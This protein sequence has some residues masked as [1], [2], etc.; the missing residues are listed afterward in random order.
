[1]DLERLY[2]PTEVSTDIRRRIYNPEWAA[3]DGSEKKQAKPKVR[4]VELGTKFVEAHPR[5]VILGGPGAGKTTFLKY[6]ALAYSDKKVFD[7]TGLTESYLPVYLHLPLLP[8]EGMDVLQAAAMQVKTKTDHRAVSFYQRLFE[9]GNIV[10]LLD[11]LDE[12]ASENREDVVRAISKFSATYPKARII[13]SCRTADYQQV[14]EGFDEV[15]VARLSPEAVKSIVKEWFFND[16]SRADKLISML[17][18]D[19]AV[20]ALTETPLLLSLLCIQYR[21]D[22]ALP[23]RKTELYRR[24]V[25]ALIRDWDASR[26]FRRDSQYSQLSDDRKEMIFECVAGENSKDGI[27]FEFSEPHL[28]VTLSDVIARFGLSGNDAKGILVEIESHH[29]ILEKC[30]A[31]TYQFSHGTMHE[32]FVAR[33]LVATR[34]EMTALKQ[35][36]DDDRWH[37]VIA[38]M[39]AII[40]DPSRMLEFLVA[41]SSTQNFKNYPTFGKR[42]AHLLLL[43]RCMTMGVAIT[44][45]LRSA[46]CDHLIKSQVHMIVQLHLDKVLPYASRRPNGIGQT[47]VRYG[48]SRPRVSIDKLLLPYRSLLN[49]VYLSPLP[50][51]AEKVIKECPLQWERRDLSVYARIGIITCLLAPIADVKP[52]EFLNY[53]ERSADELRKL[54]AE[55]VRQ[56]VVESMNTHKKGFPDLRAD[57]LHVA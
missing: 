46:I 49:E 43:Y 50:D 55:A 12:V 22:L 39:C 52:Q 41:N 10:L 36:Y 53:M 34:Q 20:A 44:P 31:E 5:T 37:T 8:R 6:L 45:P 23:K 33:H 11:S 9:T 7:K 19:P 38:F 21:N 40:N 42:L 24:C 32:Y 29:G 3:I 17:G 4:A 35:H 13:I 47:L 2:Y 57:V 15:E 27:N 48:G 16:Q 28:L 30:S 26:N 54:K 14:F 18:S 25:D 51:Y 1:M 56:I